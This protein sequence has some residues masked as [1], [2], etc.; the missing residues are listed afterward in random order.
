MGAA[1]AEVQLVQSG[2]TGSDALLRPLCTHEGG[3]SMLTQL[4]WQTTRL[5]RPL[6]A[7][8]IRGVFIQERHQ[9]HSSRLRA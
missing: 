9:P 1:R 5:K 7:R 3:A 2:A 8:N 4:L 6:S